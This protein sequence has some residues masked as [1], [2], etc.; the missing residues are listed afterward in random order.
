MFSN[1][2][3]LW[4]FGFIPVLLA[5]HFISIRKIERKAMLFANYKAM[6][7]VF[8][9]KILN[10]NYPLL[11][12]RMLVLVFLILSVA[13]TVLV[14]E[15][16]ISD[17]DYAIA[18][19]ASASMMAKD[20]QP[21]RLGA[22]KDAT[23][24][25]IQYTPEGTKI[26]LLSFSGTRLVNQVLTDD[27]QKLLDSLGSVSVMIEGGTAI[28][29]AIISAT[30]TLTN[31]GKKRAVI[32]L[33]DGQNNVGTSI[34]DALSY[35]KKYNVVVN[36]IAIGTKEGGKVGDTEFYV[37]V[38]T[39]ILKRIAESTGGSFTWAKNTQ[40]I[41]DAFTK[42]AG[43]SEQR[44]EVDLTGYFM[45]FALSLFIAELILVNTKFRTI[46]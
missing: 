36:T 13:G 20:Y 34:D 32:L 41:K 23:A 25:F 26:S 5:V 11:L 19:D 38:D 10:K 3:Y 1:P 37:G 28:G 44:V 35:A 6:E 46:P 29:E 4:F 2:L 42:I 14:Y 12:I 9:K 30:E 45:A 8:G 39:E 22:A 16:F 7:H 15:G 33:T 43:G 21:T 27:K 40:E 31:A 17:F 18:M 24:E